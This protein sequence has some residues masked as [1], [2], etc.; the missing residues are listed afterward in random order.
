MT[1]DDVVRP[2]ADAASE[3]PSQPAGAKGEAAGAKESDKISPEEE[4]WREQVAAAREKANQTQ[5]AAEETELRVTDLRNELSRPG[6]T[7]NER[8]GIA[9]DLDAVGRQVLDLRA[10]ARAAADELNKLL[11][12]GR[13]KG[14]S[15][16]PGPKAQTDDGKPNNQYYRERYDKLTQQLRD[17][18]RRVQLYENRLREL[19]QR[20]NNNSVSGDNF[21][22]SR[23]QQ[24][25]DDAQRQ[26]EEAQAAYDKA[27]ADMD[28]LM[29]E[30][31]RAGVPPG[32]F[33]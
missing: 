18:E 12:Q 17:A 2:K 9:A 23:L 6:H 10:Q 3:S 32:V 14:F 30:A 28:A 11:D 8:N 29:E 15:E 19:N 25:R 13:A 24:D 27:R 1:T 4:A 7:P 5:R 31:R 16:A 21:Y 33:R 22:I 20:I 26:M